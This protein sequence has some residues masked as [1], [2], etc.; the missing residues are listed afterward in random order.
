LRYT[1]ALMMIS[2]VLLEKSWW[3]EF[4]N[5]KKD[6]KTVNRV[7]HTSCPEV[8]RLTCLWTARVAHS[9]HCWWFFLESLVSFCQY[10]F[11]S[12]SDIIIK[13]SVCFQNL[14]YFISLSL[15]LL[16]YVSFKIYN[17]KESSNTMSTCLD[18]FSLFCQEAH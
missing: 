18:C 16:N 7:G 12:I 11:N 13:V 15:S 9:G 6:H 1:E 17:L 3:D 10:L 4:N 8:S 2:P 14:F 5:T